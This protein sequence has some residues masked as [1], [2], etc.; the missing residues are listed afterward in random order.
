MTT[1]LTFSCNEETARLAKMRLSNR[2]DFSRYL[3]KCLEEVVKSEAH[4]PVDE[5]STLREELV[6]LQAQNADIT[7]RLQKAEANKQQVEQEKSTWV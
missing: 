5:I 6:K 4:D 7:L 3:Q 2:G 1:V